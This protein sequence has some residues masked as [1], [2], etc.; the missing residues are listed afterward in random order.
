M[1]CGTLRGETMKNLLSLSVTTKAG[2]LIASSANAPCQRN[3]T[4]VAKKCVRAACFADKGN[5]LKSRSL[6]M[7]SGRTFTN[8]CRRLPSTGWLS[9]APLPRMLFAPLDRITGIAAGCSSHAY[10]VCS[11]SIGRISA[12]HSRQWF[13]SHCPPRRLAFYAAAI[14]LYLATAALQ[15]AKTI[16]FALEQIKEL[17]GWL[18]RSRRQSCVAGK[19]S[20]CFVR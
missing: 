12:R 7:P 16:R 8:L 5:W 14:P 3:C 2:I 13:G 9:A 17:S 11:I 10:S 18:L 1:T 15:R 6:H 4:E 20:N 19:L